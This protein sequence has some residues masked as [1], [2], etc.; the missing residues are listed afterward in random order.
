MKLLWIFPLAGLL[1]GICLGTVLPV[2]PVGYSGYVG[3][4]I[5]A[6]A[7]SVLGGFKSA[8]YGQFKLSIFLSGF[9]GNALIA[10]LLLF[11]GEQLD[12]P[13]LLAAVVVFARR[14]LQNFAEIRR[15]LLNLGKKKDKIHTR[16]KMM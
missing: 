1:G 12:I 7:D 16:R 13:F 15:N 5:L 4:G 10:V 3:M 14:I 11:L 6:C 9:L 2:L 8:L